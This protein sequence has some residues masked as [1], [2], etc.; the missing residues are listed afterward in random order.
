MDTEYRLHA[1]SGCTAS[2][3]R[4]TYRENAGRNEPGEPIA[5]LG[6]GCRFP[7]GVNS[8]DDLW[9]LVSE[10]RDAITEF[11]TDRGWNLDALFGPDPS[12]PRATHVRTGGFVENA[13]DFD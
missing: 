9:Q 5:I 7:G 3:A 1:Q 2:G 8:P 13:G 12:A 6:I 10:E 11:P 4:E